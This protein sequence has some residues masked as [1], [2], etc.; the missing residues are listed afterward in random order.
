VVTPNNET[1]DAYGDDGRYHGIPR[2]DYAVG[3]S[4]NDVG[5]YPKCR[6]DQDV[7]LG[8]SKESE[9]M[10]EQYD[11]TSKNWQ[12]IAAIVVPIQ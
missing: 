9:E 11:V 12:E 6:E 4:G 5:D 2:E 3:R 1:N 10:L 7:N 8:M